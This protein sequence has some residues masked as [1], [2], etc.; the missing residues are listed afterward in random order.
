MSSA[1]RGDRTKTWEGVVGAFALDYH[2]RLTSGTSHVHVHACAVGMLAAAGGC[3]LTDGWEVP[4]RRCRTVVG[5]AAR[6]GKR[7]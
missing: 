6:L 3:A 5:A 4:P 1:G 2:T 7:T